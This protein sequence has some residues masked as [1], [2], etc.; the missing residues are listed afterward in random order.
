MG[1]AELAAELRAMRKEHMKP[2][3][4]MRSKDISEEIESLKLRLAETPHTAAFPSVPQK[5]EVAAVESIKVAKAA[6]FPV[7]PASGKAA[8]KG[9]KKA[10]GRPKKAADPMS[11]KKTPAA[12]SKKK[13][14]M[15]KLLSMMDSDDE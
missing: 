15:A 1:K 13:A 5:A 3:S 7:K 2:I 4:K 9:E 12:G 11:A 8:P 6:E 14:M 10:V